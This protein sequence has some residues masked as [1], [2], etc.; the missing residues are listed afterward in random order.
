[1]SDTE[2]VPLGWFGNHRKGG[3]QGRDPHFILTSETSQKQIHLEDVCW[4][5]QVLFRSD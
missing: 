4:K 5:V 2:L 3:R 1:M